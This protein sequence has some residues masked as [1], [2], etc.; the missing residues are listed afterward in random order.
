MADVRRISSNSEFENAAGYCR[1]VVDDDY[2]H[3]AGTT[4]FDYATMSIADDVAEQADQAFS[5][6]IEVLARARC[7]LAD[8]V[9]VRYYLSDAADFGIL[10]PVFKRHLG[11]TPPAATAV[12]AQLID[13]RIKIEIEATARRRDA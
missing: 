4:G 3:V 12:V 8:V 5:N 9:R 1:A 7:S 11:A 6:I 10:A 2:V 13:P